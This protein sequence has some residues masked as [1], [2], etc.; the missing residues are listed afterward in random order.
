MARSIRTK[1]KMLT[2]MGLVLILT[3][4]CGQAAKHELAFRST[5][6]KTWD[7]AMTSSDKAQKNIETDYAA[8]NVAAVV[9]EYRILEKRFSDSA[10]ETGKLKPADGYVKLKK[11]TLTYYREGASYYRVVARVIED[12]G[13]NY[14]TAQEGTLNAQEK[15]WQQATKSLEQELKKKR[16]ELK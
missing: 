1:L 4:G 7:A 13:G 16:F 3:A 9:A 12:T 10:D 5:F 2:T 14:S 8:G 15:K 6:K 11:L